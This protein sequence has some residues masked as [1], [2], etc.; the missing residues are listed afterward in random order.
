MVIGGS[1]AARSAVYALTKLM[2]YGTVYTVNC[3]ATEA[4]APMATCE[5][6]YG[7]D[8]LVRTTSV[9][10]V[11]G[12]ESQELLSQA[13]QTVLRS[14]RMKCVFDRSMRPP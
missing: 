10:Q 9:E 4:D 11:E 3:D 6:H 12:L 7:K 5:M 1:G 14:L 8:R 2:S 13:Y